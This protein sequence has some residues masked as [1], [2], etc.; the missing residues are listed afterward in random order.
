MRPVV[1]ILV[2]S[3]GCAP[4]LAQSSS[5]RNPGPVQTPAAKPAKPA[6]KKPA[7]ATN[8]AGSRR[9]KNKEADLLETQER[10]TL[11]AAIKDQVGWKVVDDPVIFGA[12]LGLPTRLVPQAGQGKSGGRWTSV[13]GEVQIETFRADAQTIAFP[14]LFEQQK[15]QTGRNTESSNI[16]PDLFVL[17][18]LQGLKKF[19]VRAQLKDGDIRGLTVL[20]DQ[21]MEGIMEPLVAAMSSAFAPF[22][23][24]A[25]GQIT[26]RKVEYSTGIAVSKTG[27]FVGD[28]Q[29]TDGCHIIVVAGYGNAERLAGDEASDTALLRVY[30]ASSGKPMA[31]TTEPPKGADLTLIGVADPQMQGGGGAVSLANA[32]LGDVSGATVSLS[33]APLQG[34]SGAAAVDSQGRFVG[35]AEVRNQT[36]AGPAP[37]AVQAMLVPTATIRK[38]LE[39]EKIPLATGG[40]TVEDAKAAIA[41]VICIRK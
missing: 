4:A 40:A 24:D 5:D 10:A 18:G 38:F 16:R 37:A 36:V 33:P 27:H 3:L 9:S 34:F 31:F 6:A 20:Y 15:K 11:A 32:R 29:A 23:D 25:A 1:P 8:G 21:A 12:R 26:R 22:G 41:R 13:R 19:Y 28:R 39:R 14:T 35:M 2:L 17:T 7:A 30:G